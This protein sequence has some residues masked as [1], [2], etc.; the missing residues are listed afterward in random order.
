[1]LQAM[2]P[3]RLIAFRRDDLGVAGP[4]WRDD[5]HE[6]DRWCRLLAES[7]I[8]ASSEE[9]ELQVPDVPPP[10]RSATVVH[11]G[12]AAASRRWPADRFAAVARALAAGGHD[13]VVTGSEAERSLAELVAGAAGVCQDRVLAGRLDLARMA[14]LVASA[15]LVVCGDTGVG[16]LATAYRV[17]SVLLFGPMSPALWGPPPGRPQ[18]RVLWHADRAT[19]PT[20]TGTPHPAV[21][22]I[23]VGE[24][25]AAVDALD[26]D[27]LRPRRPS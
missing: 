7:G 10:V 11:P 4:S 8:D 1:V 15:R 3:K 25:L 9:L 23:E 14:A 16:H 17:P 6:V 18:H 5:E 13:V 24:V 20:E 19:L 22:A 27:G 12:A 21:L 26:L 2:R